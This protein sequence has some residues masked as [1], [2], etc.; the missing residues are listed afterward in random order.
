MTLRTDWTE[1]AVLSELSPSLTPRGHALVER[2]AHHPH[3]PRW[4]HRGGDRLEA[5]DLEAVAQFR[6]QLAAGRRRIGTREAF[7]A[8]VEA[9]ARRRAR[10]PIFETH[11]PL[12]FHLARDWTELPTM[13]REDLV[14]RPDEC[15]PRDA[16][17]ERLLIYRTSGTT[18]HALLV[19]HD[20]V[21]VACYNVFMEEALARYGVTPRFH[22][23]MIASFLVGC[24]AHTVA[25]AT[26]LSVWKGA[27]FA[28]LT[29]HPDAWPSPDSPH[30][31]F[32]AMQPF[33]LTGDPLSFAEMLHRGIPVR[34]AALVP[35]AVALAEP[36]KQ[37]LEKTYGC[38]VIDW[39]SLTETGPLGYACPRGG[40][41]HL[42]APDVYVEVLDRRGRPVGPGETGEITVSGGRNPFFPLLRYRTG[43]WGRLATK[44]C[45]CG[46]PTPRL[47]DLEGRVPV[48]LLGTHGRV[49]PQDV[50][51]V[52][53]EHPIFQHEL[54]QHPDR[55]CDLRVRP[56]PGR[57][58]DLDALRDQLV[59]VFGSGIALRITIDPQLGDRHAGR[60]IHPYAQAPAPVPT[61][62]PHDAPHADRPY[63]LHVA[64]TNHCNR[65]CPW[66]STYSSPRGSTWLSVRQ[67]L[68]ALPAEGDFEV[69]LEGGE[70]TI[71]PDFWEF[72]RLSRE[73][74]RCT[75]LVIG[76]NGVVLPRDAEGLDAWLARIGAPLV[77]KL[78]INHHLLD[79]D[80]GLL[81]LASLLRERMRAAGGDRELVLNV[82]LRRGYADDDA[83]VAEAVRTAG[84]EDCANIFYLQRYG[85]A[86]NEA[87]W[88]E[89]FIVGT[90]FGL[91]N[92]DGTRFGPDLVGRSEAMGQLP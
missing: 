74:P 81:A 53:R 32:E 55:T 9:T 79:R 52:L 88:D 5:A 33:F 36:L 24:Q 8:M 11:I 66:C 83:A 47:V 82:R 39:Y 10:V 50:T 19:P 62:R 23:D 15:I 73:H 31:Y 91:L 35:T 64:V 37:A 6:E 40:G 12:G 29:L 34:P 38:P 18:G 46:D 56:I 44:P 49:H 2:L 68:D 65:A 87:D 59:E 85:R 78:S 20:R 54:V 75:K 25:Y 48:T 89:P 27:G 3:A 72:V 7:E 51:R 45:P 70:P 43:D 1:M 41:Y 71:H 57:A 42:L 30:R 60:K 90:R 13:S 84:L 92:P 4:N 67:F 21:A 86:K 58:L 76:T 17:L 63:R 16:D 14:S 22:D 77:V 69:Q 26:S 80:P 28:K 61:P